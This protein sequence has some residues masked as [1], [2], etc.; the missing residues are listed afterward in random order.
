MSVI[1]DYILKK[2]RLSDSDPRVDILANN[3]IKVT[4]Y[5]QI[6]AAA[7]TVAIPAGATIVLDDKAEGADAYVV[8]IVGGKPSEVFP[9]DSL[10]VEV[11]VASFDAL[12]NYVL[13]GT[14]SSYPVA[15]VF[16]IKTTA[17]NWS[18]IDLDYVMDSE[19]L[20]VQFED[21]R[22]DPSLSTLLYDFIQEQLN[23]PILICDPYDFSGNTYPSTGGTGPLGAIMAG[24]QFDA[25]VGGSPPGVTSPLIAPYDYVRAKIDN[26]T[27][28]INDWYIGRSSV[29]STAP[30]PIITTVASSAAPTPVVSTNL[31]TADVLLV[32]AQ[33]SAAV[34][35]APSGTYTNCK[36]LIIRIRDNGTA[37]ALSFNAVYNFS[38]MLSAPTTTTVNKT[39][40]LGFRYNSAN[41]KW[42][43]LAFVDNFT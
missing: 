13:T 9:E 1:Y 24:N 23:T 35:A 5:Q 17:L 11:D 22:G 33:N 27:Q 25:L 6:S 10:G 34:F 19:E 29:P 28:S 36:N 12:G 7:G 32:T 31:A 42:D 20:N 16:T 18:N 4:Y 26:P 38:G 37:R 14:P 30:T 21:L 39:M 3:E 43:C 41:S 40:Y 8:T 15:L 2:L